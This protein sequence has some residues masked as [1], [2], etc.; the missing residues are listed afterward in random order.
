MPVAD[1]NKTTIHYTFEGPAQ[2]AVV[3]FS[4]SLASNLH[5]WDA[6]VPVLVKA[7]Y[8]VLRYDRRGHGQSGA[9]QG[10]Y[11]MEML[12][13]D[14]AGLMDALGLAKVHFNADLGAGG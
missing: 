14:A 1:V 9:P 7:G 2:G 10:P 5:M 8:R 3:M 12:T 13:A 4:T 11:T 6:Q